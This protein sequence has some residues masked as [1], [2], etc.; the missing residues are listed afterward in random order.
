MVDERLPRRRPRKASPKRKR[1]Q[2]VLEEESS[3]GWSKPTRQRKARTLTTFEELFDYDS[4]L[5]AKIGFGAIAPP[6]IGIIFLARAARKGH[7]YFSANPAAAIFILLLLVPVGA[8]AGMALSVKDVVRDRMS[9]GRPV[10]FPLKMLFG[11][12]CLSLLLIWVPL[13]FLGTLIMLI[14]SIGMI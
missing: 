9:E 7:D 4:N 3:D 11:F 6:I 1:K 14:L 10:A 2:T 13:A 5:M 12:G 8:C